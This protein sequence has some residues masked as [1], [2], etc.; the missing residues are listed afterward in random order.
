M[1]AELAEHREVDE[2]EVEGLDDTDE[3]VKEVTPV[4]CDNLSGDQIWDQSV[5]DWLIWSEKIL[6]FIPFG[7]IRPTR[8]Q[9]YTPVIN[10]Q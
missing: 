10:V 4:R 6:R 5:S 9:T 3:A 8:A 2:I 1:V 7:A